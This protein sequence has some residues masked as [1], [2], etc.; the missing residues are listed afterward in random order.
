VRASEVGEGWLGE[1]HEEVQ[2]E[3]EADGLLLEGDE[4]EYILELLMREA[5]PNL[6]AGAHGTSQGRTRHP[7][8]QE[9]EKPWEET[10]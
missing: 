8:G 4:R 7:N 6:E 9:E 10:P 2:S 1:A 5:P 3:A